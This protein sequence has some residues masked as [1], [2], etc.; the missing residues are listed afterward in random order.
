M[1]YI[2]EKF[3]KTKS[4][5]ETDYLSEMHVEL[6]NQDHNNKQIRRIQSGSQ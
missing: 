3:Y 6:T 1:I 4:K 5:K 2:Q